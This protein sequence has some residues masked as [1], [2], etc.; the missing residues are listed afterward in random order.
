MDKD[1]D[2]DSYVTQFCKDGWETRYTRPYYYT[3]WCYGKKGAS[4][5]MKSKHQ[6]RSKEYLAQHKRV[7]HERMKYPSMQCNHQATSKGNPTQHKRAIHEGVK[8]PCMYCRQQIYFLSQFQ[9]TSTS[10]L[11]DI[12]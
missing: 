10:E 4:P 11:L 1:N 7:V 6:A 9:N 3:G 2:W 8:Y 12:C 5:C